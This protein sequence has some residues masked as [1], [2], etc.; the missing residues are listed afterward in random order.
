M[1]FIH[2]LVESKFKV[3]NVNA[4]KEPIN[5]A[6]FNMA[7][8]QNKSYDELINQ[9]NYN[10]KLWGMKL[11]EQPNGR[12]IMSLDF[13]CYDKN[14]D[15]NDENTLERLNN[16]KNGAKNTNGMY[17]S[18][19]TGNMNVLVD[20]SKSDTIK[21]C[22]EVAKSPTKFK[23]GELEILLSG[24]QVIP[25]SQTINKKTKTLGNPR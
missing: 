18:S 11:G 8:W 15:D 2:N 12:Y 23:V 14:I 24:N 22:I 9:H 6:G 5:K 17:Y 19:T 10:S 16:Y 1:D 21:K 7:N 20:Y 25:P 3:Y 4:N 13:D